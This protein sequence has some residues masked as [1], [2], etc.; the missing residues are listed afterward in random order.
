MKNIIE[1]ISNIE[2]RLDYIEITLGISPDNQN[3]KELKKQLQEEEEKI[4]GFTKSQLINLFGWAKNTK[5]QFLTKSD[6][7]ELKKWGV[8]KTFYP[9]SPDNYEDIKL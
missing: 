6:F 8:L 7:E 9:D 3:K 2:K 5:I 4:N 1:K